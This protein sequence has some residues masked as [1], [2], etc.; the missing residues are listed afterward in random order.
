MVRVYLI[1]GANSGCGL[2]AARQLAVHFAS[3][4][5]NV[6][7][8]SHHDDG[9]DG[10]GRTK[11]Y[12]LC[13]SEAKARQ[14]I[15]DIGTDNVHFLLF[16]A[17]HDADTI[18]LNV[19]NNIPDSEVVAGIVLNAGGFGDIPSSLEKQNMNSVVKVD[20]VVVP[21]KKACSIAQANIIGHAILVDQLLKSGKFGPSARIVA[22]GSEAVLTPGAEMD[23]KNA[24]MAERLAGT[25][26]TPNNDYGWIKG[27]LALYWTAFARHH[28]ELYVLTVSP[29]AVGS[30]NL[31]VQGG[32]TPTIRF[33]SRVFMFFVGAHSVQDGAKRY[34]DA[35]LDR[36]MPSSSSTSNTENELASGSVLLSRKGFTKD[37]GR[38]DQLKKGQFVADTSLQDEAWDAVNQF[39]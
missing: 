21:T 2:E 4:N 25:V 30:T 29:G 26:R 6:Q 23:W 14:A 1:T 34:V 3:S 8:H 32:A 38:I 28:P 20:G 31:L 11:I 13:R 19:V 36:D 33:F 7:R 18:R 24:N 10:V 12:L 17:T 15:I 37:Y 22:V 5:T 27:I 9:S 16:D 39:L 35:L